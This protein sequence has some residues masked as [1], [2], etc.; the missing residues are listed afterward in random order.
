MGKA[1]RLCKCFLRAVIMLCNFSA[2]NEPMQVPAPSCGLYREIR[3]SDQLPQC[4]SAAPF[5]I[6]T[7]MSPAWPPAAAA[8][9]YSSPVVPV[10][11]LSAL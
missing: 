9:G 11:Y 6:D 1:A 3:L 7:L 8:E 10:L 5:E 4:R 2:L